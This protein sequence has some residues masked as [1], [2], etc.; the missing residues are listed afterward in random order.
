MTSPRHLTC[1]LLEHN[2]LRHGHRTQ[3]TQRNRQWYRRHRECIFLGYHKPCPYWTVLVFL[4]DVAQFGQF[5]HYTRH[6]QKYVAVEVDGYPVLCEVNQCPLVLNRPRWSRSP[7]K[8]SQHY[9][10]SAVLKSQAEGFNWSLPKAH[11]R[12]LGALLCKFLTLGGGGFKSGPRKICPFCPHPLLC[13]SVAQKRFCETRDN[14][15]WLGF[16][17]ELWQ[18]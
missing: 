9:G 3:G 1:A 4:G 18:E 12:H 8:E 6:V 13:L 7:M 15:N 14:R 16:K 17:G 5:W 10:Q 2:N 11:K